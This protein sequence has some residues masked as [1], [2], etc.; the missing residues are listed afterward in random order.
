MYTPNGI[1]T[2]F[3]PTVP[4]KIPLKKTKFHKTT[5]CS[6]ECEHAAVVRQY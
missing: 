6:S 1:G 3:Y 2:Q 4:T 5:Y